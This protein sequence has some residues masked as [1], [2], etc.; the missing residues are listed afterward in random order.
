MLDKA[1][2]AD[3]AQARALRLLEEPICYLRALAHLLHGVNTSNDPDDHEA[4]VL[5]IDL[6]AE[7]TADLKS[8]F[9]EALNIEGA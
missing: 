6:I 8:R 1:N 4:Q 2:T 5:L 9:Y 7:R 3:A